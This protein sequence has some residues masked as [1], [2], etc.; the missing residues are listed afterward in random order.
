MK[1][2]ILVKFKE[3]VTAE[4]KV[5]L[6]PEIKAL[7]DRLLD[8]EGIHNIEV[9]P[10]VINR[11]NRYDLLIRIEMDEATLPVY[12]ASEPHHIW[13]NEYG[14]LLEKKAIFDYE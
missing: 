8:M 12:D 3:E 14:H 5:A 7:F 6:Q 11:P 2:C 10:N 9:I 1:H 4:K 13:K